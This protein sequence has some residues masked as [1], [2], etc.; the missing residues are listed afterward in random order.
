MEGAVLKK[1][2][3][4]LVYICNHYGLKE[5]ASYWQKVIEINSWQQ[6]RISNLIVEK[7]FGTLSGKK[8]AVLGFAFKANTNDTRESP[9]INICKELLQEGANLYIYDPQV[10]KKQIGMD[11]EL[12]DNDND[13]DYKNFNSNEGS[14][15]FAKSIFDSTKNADAIL[16]LTE[17]NEFQSI[18]WKEIAENMRKPS[19]IFD[20]RCIADLDEAHK[21][22]I[23]IWR[24]GVD[25]T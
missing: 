24:V 4:N 15:K 23:N 5:V 16:I 10:N 17:W 22:G 11:L 14:W 2:I 9:A 3:L 25:F 18:N 12:N 8:I 20:T 1:D 6:K 7:L 13:N 21:Y 19:W